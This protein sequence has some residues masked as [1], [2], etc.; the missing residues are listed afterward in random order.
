MEN[1][2]LYDVKSNGR[3]YTWNNKQARHS[4]VMIKIDRVMANHQWEEAFPNVE[5]TF[6]LERDF[7][8][9]PMVVYFFNPIKTRNPF[10]FY[11]HWGKQEEFMPTVKSILSNNI[12]GHL[13]FQILKKTANVE[14]SLEK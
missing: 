2:G 9:T 13:N 7:D 10:K 5:A 1:C 11:N 14:K 3:F 6:H 4:Q 8:H 12:S